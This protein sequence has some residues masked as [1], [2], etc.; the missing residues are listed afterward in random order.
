MFKNA[1]ITKESPIPVKPKKLKLLSS[2]ANLP[3]KGYCNNLV[4]IFVY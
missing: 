3:K 4:T 2:E 1:S